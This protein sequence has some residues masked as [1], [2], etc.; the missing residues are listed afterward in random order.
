MLA[1][2]SVKVRLLALITVPLLGIVFIISLALMDMRSLNQATE[3]VFEDLQ[4]MTAV[5]RVQRAY[6]FELPDALQEHHA[7]VTSSAEFERAL[8]SVQALGATSIAT[9]RGFDLSPQEQVVV[10][11]ILSGVQALEPEFARWLEMSGRNDFQG[12]SGVDLQRMIDRR[13]DPISEA[14]FSF[15]DLQQQEAEA[16]FHA[17]AERYARDFWLFMGIGAGLILFSSAFALI[18]FRSV[19]VPIDELRDVMTEVEQESNLKIRA[20]VNGKNEIATLGQRFNS[21]LDSFQDV[22]INVSAASNQVAASSE[23]LSAVSEEVSNIARE[24]EAQTTQIATAVTQMAAAVEEVAKSA[25]SA[26]ESAEQ[27][28]GETK[29]GRDQVAKNMKAMEMLSDSVMGASERL[30]I[31]DERTQEI[32]KVMDVIQGIAEQ[33][34]LLALNAAIE[35]A[36]AGEQGRGFAVV[37]DEVRSLASNT[38][39]STATIQETTERLRRGASEA[40]EAMTVSASQANESLELARATGQAFK[41]VNVAVSE[42]VEVNVQ[43]STATEEQ[44]TVANEITESVNGLSG[45]IAEVVTGA[46][47]CAAASSELSSL[48][49][50]LREQ[51]SRFKVA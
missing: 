23:E 3:S 17:A 12:M 38:K 4:E 34:N 30:K 49:H 27:A 46:N 24:Q 41:Q 1:Q 2:L 31:L 39:D 9:L 10:D 42:V 20:Q 19:Q 44:A 7:G 43:I 13:I 51:V 11:A 37:A 25:Q 26:M 22:L 36:R 32:A 21:M 5:Q 8:T 15:I 6:V 48:A 33:T 29:R 35:A 28:E 45:S 40:V 16:S 50:N 47:Q 18:I 14:T